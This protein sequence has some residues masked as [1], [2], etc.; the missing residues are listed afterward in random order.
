MA[1]NT[2]DGK[3]IGDPARAHDEGGDL[4][5]YTMGDADSASSVISRNDCQLN[6]KTTL[7]YEVRNSYTVVVTATDPFGA[8]ANRL[9]IVNV[10]NEDDT[11]VIGVLP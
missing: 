2:E 11:V 3:N 7:S 10:T 8:A 1:E 9:V 5:I 4:R 6:M